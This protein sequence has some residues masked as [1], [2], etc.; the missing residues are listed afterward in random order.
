MS[1]RTWIVAFCLVVAAASSGCESCSYRHH[2]L[3]PEDAGACFDGCA[4]AGIDG[5]SDTVDGGQGSDAGMDAGDASL[6]DGGS[7]A[8]TD[9]GTDAAVDAGEDASVCVP[10]TEV[11][12]GADDD[13]DGRTDEELLE[14]AADD[15]LTFDLPVGDML[16][17]DQRG[18]AQL[19]PRSPES[20]WLLHKP[21]G[22]SDGATGLEVSSIEQFG[23]Q[24][25]GTQTGLIPTSRVFLGASLG[26]FVA[27]LWRSTD[28]DMDTSVDDLVA[29]DTNL[30]LLEAVNGQLVVRA[31][32]ELLD[33]P[34]DISELELSRD[35]AGELRILAVYAP[36]SI[37]SGAATLTPTVLHSLRYDADAGPPALVEVDETTLP[38]NARPTVH[39]LR[40]PCGDGWLLGYWTNN[41][42]NTQAEREL[43]VRSLSLEGD[44]DF[45][46]DPLL[47]VSGHALQG[48]AS[49]PACSR[50]SS[51]LLLLADAPAAVANGP[52]NLDAYELSFDNTD[53]SISEVNTVVVADQIAFTT[54]VRHGGL[55]YVTLR[56]FDDTPTGVRELDVVNQRVRDIPT[57]IAQGGLAGAALVTADVN[58]YFAPTQGILR[59]GDGLL[60]TFSNAKPETSPLGRET[61]A[62]THRLRCP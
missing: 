62:V 18:F 51:P 53:A 28:A 55:W 41:G 5:G 12:N 56:N 34:A 60:V 32:L 54:S 47:N 26:E 31:G 29:S 23:A 57:P 20:A 48:F 21:L 45:N 39:A 10:A 1:S 6:D 17:N 42:T 40:R 36:W 33:G 52:R 59:L 2:D 4:E 9:A 24:I 22:T 30:T 8:G 61:I 37:T 7:D 3:E 11:C 27:V 38:A 43:Y 44:I 13:C 14:M 19:L 50:A 46:A 58:M 15:S 35:E 16:A 25:G 49:A